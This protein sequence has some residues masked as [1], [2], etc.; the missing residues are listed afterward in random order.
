MNLSK[1]QIL[2]V[3]ALIGAI[4]G[5]GAAYLLMTAPAEKPGEELE[6][7]TAADLVELTGSAAVL[8]RRVDDLRRKL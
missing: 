3:G 7:V 4:L 2:L 8:I 1:K 6:P 5:T